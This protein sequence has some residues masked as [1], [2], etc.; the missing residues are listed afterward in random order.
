[1]LEGIGGAV[2]SVARAAAQAA[3][4]TVKAATKD[5]SKKVSTAQ[6]DQGGGSQPASSGSQPA[7]GDGQ[8]AGGG[9]GAGAGQ[10]APQTNGVETV[11]ALW[12]PPDNGGQTTKVVPALYTGPAEGAGPPVVLV[13][14][15]AAAG[16]I[17]PY[18]PTVPAD[19]TIPADPQ[20][21]E[22]EPTFPELNDPVSKSLKGLLDE[23]RADKT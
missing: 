16:P 23:V 14:G 11:P 10:G 22:A 21:G 6:K 2:A 17:V 8:A 7:S 1:M 5:F 18:G 9:Q 19:P 20:T 13:D 15:E 4:N 3:A 12:I